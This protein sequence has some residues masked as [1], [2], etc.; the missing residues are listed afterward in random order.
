MFGDQI[1]D[2][3][4]LSFGKPYYFTP[5]YGIRGRPR[6]NGLIILSHEEY[7]TYHETKNKAEAKA[8][9]ETFT[10]PLALRDE[11]GAMLEHGSCFALY[12]YEDGHLVTSRC[13]VDA[14]ARTPEGSLVVLIRGEWL[15]CQVGFYTVTKHRCM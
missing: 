7:I 3:L 9:A 11:D 2:R 8:A 1:F 6:A 5:E 15:P 12:T 10:F 4:S 13:L 14:L